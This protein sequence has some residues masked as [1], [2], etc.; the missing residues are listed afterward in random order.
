MSRDSRLKPGSAQRGELLQPPGGQFYS[1]TRVPAHRHVTGPLTPA[2]L[3]IQMVYTIGASIAAL[4]AIPLGAESWRNSGRPRAPFARPLHR[5]V[6]PSL[7]E[8]CVHRARAITRAAGGQPAWV[9]WLPAK[10]GRRIKVVPTVAPLRM[11]ELAD[12]RPVASRVWAWQ[13]HQSSSGA[14]LQLAEPAHFS[15]FAGASALHRMRR[16]G[17][18]SR[19]RWF[20]GVR[21]G[22]TLERLGSG[23]PS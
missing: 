7:I 5:H 15:T 12:R 11:D 8:H 20:R 17:H 2:Q 6:R 9:I 3:V 1:P 22:P 18:R 4:R 16:V 10:R 19:A 23:P 14:K 13:Y 21:C